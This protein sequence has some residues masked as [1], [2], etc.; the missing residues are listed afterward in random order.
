[1]VAASDAAGMCQAAVASGCASATATGSCNLKPAFAGAGAA[2]S[3][4]AAVCGID[5]QWTAG[6]SSCPLTPNLRYNVYRGTTPDFVPAPGN[7][8]AACVAGPASYL[9]TA[10]LASGVTYYYVVRAEDDSTGNGGA[11]G[12]NE[13]QNGRVV[14]GTAYGT[15]LQGSPGTW[16]DAGGDGT[17]LLRLN[18]AGTGD[19]PDPA[20]RF[21][22]TASDAGANHTAGG[23]FA[24]RNAGPASADHYFPSTCAEMQTPPLTIGAASVN[25]TYWERHQVEY[26]WDGIVVESSI[27]GGPWTTV[28]APSNSIPAGCSATASV[29]NWENLSCT[30]APPGNSCGYPATQNAINGP[31]AGGTDCNTWS[32]STAVTSYAQRCHPLTVVEPGSTIQ[33]RWRFT[34]DEAAEFSGFYLDDVAVTNILLPNACVPNECGGQLDGTACDDGNACTQNDACQSGAC[35]GGSPVVCAPLDACHVAGTCNT[36]SGLCSNPPGNDGASCDDGNVCTAGTTCSGG[37]CGGGTPVPPA[38]VND[39]VAFGTDSQTLSW[40]DPPGDY[41][42]YRGLRTTPWTYDQTCLQSHVASGSV[43]D[44]AAPAPGDIFFYL[45]TRITACGESTPGNDSGGSPRPNPAP[46]P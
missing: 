3:D 37:V 40:S 11:C 43:S 27:N 29:T 6:A 9:D 20:W 30:G 45:I 44:P 35:A 15:G 34:S 18:V 24:Y 38:P 7:R 8:I 10:N 22:K 4:A 19:T 23:A 21:V 33:F 5:L 42:V 41:N 39:S 32:T 28:P 17:S 16:I 46:C 26:H 2:S 12:G 36:Q 25:L 1:V 31:L 14:G 13:E